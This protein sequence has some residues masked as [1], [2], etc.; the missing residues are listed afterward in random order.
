MQ[1]AIASLIST[2]WYQ[3]TFSNPVASLHDITR[4][5]KLSLEPQN[6]WEAG[7]QEMQEKAEEAQ[8]EHWELEPEQ[9]VQLSMVAECP[10][11]NVHAEAYPDL[12]KGESVGKV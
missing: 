2:A 12:V 9:K 11:I 1:E 5:I 3:S 6:L 10:D 8:E 7:T 4:R